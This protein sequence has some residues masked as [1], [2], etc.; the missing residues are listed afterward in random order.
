[1]RSVT[2]ALLLQVVLV[3]AFAAKGKPEV[4]VN[5]VKG[6]LRDKATQNLP[7]HTEPKTAA[8]LRCNSCLA[9]SQEVFES[10]INLRELRDGKPSNLEQLETLQDVCAMMKDEYGLSVA[11]NG[12]VSLKFDHNSR[13]PYQAKG[14]W[15]SS[16][17]AQRCADITDDFEDRILSLA[18]ASHKR[19]TK[20]GKA[21]AVKLSKVSRAELEKEQTAFQQALCVKMDRACPTSL[22]NSASDADNEL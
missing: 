14:V 12:E 7:D 22:F 13:S 11:D 18:A 21:A 6:E 16:M 2:V 15:V 20:S 10:L 9:V 3:A 1:M 19:L 4:V 17:I 8:A 5:P